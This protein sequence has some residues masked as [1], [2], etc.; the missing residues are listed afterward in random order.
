MKKVLLLLA[1]GYE[2]YEAS[3]FIDVIGWNLVDGDGT[4]ELFTCGLRKQ[5]NS[6]FNQKCIVDYVIDEIDID[7]F[8]A[9][10]IPGGFE[11]YDF[12]KDAYDDR[13]LNV[14]RLFNSNNK[15]IA[16]ICVAAL[17]IGKS[18]VLINKRGTTYNINSNRQDTL[19]SYGVTVI[20]EP[21]VIDD[22]IITS[23]NPSTA[24]DVAF[25]LLELLTSKSNAYYIKQIMGFENNV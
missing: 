10:A 11:N 19:R 13:F 7:N 6:S 24:L 8:D 25:L 22:N 9:L 17:P 16:S 5:I 15:V 12:Y 14:I 1:D 21:I 20:N 4:T 23:W 3:V 2:C 18:G